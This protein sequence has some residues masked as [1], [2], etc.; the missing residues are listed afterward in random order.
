M[1]LASIQLTETRESAHVTSLL[2]CCHFVSIIIDFKGDYECGT[3]Y[4][5][6]FITYLELRF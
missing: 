5:T 3:V 4:S 1:L 2:L 6:T